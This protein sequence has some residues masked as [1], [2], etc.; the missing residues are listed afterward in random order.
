MS[1]LCPARPSRAVIIGAG[2]IGSHLAASLRQDMPLLVIDR[3][4]RVRDSFIARGIESVSPVDGREA[5]AMTGT[6]RF[7]SGDVAILVTSASAAAP[8]AMAVPP[9]VPMVCLSNGLTPDLVEA[10]NGSLS[11]G[12]VEFAMSSSSPGRSSCTRA[13]W[14]TLQRTSPGDATAWLAAALDPRR[15][16][17]R[18]TDDI[19]GHRHGKLMLN[20]SLDP[21]AAII[22]GAIGDVFRRT[23]S[24]RAFRVLLGEAIAVARGAGW[25]LRA[26]QGVRP[27]VLSAVFA[28]PMLRIVA[29]RAA[30]RQARAVASTLSREIQRG[31]LGEADHLCG[32]IA[33][34]GVRVGVATPGHLRAMDILRR[35][36]GEP[37][38]NGGR[39]ELA[40][41]LVQR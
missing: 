33:R 19:D 6:P 12:V 1:A 26:V 8:A 30:A 5:A 17:S 2:A 31:D 22:G 39:P 14:L 25:R 32:A 16:R 21:V 28:T 23:A 15:Q 41:E 3:D 27:D 35:I 7:R 20:S 10:R 37:G 29:A 9:W 18:L 11:Y 34:E 13:G 24:F 4:E 40:R 38:G 36:A